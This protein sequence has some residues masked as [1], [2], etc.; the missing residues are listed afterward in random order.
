M[1]TPEL[2]QFLKKAVQEE[3]KL[4][5]GLRGDIDKLQK[6]LFVTEIMGTPDYLDSL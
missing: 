3:Q 6:D 5:L 2:I 4:M 1:L